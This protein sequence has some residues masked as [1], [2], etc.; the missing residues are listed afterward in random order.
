M[1]KKLTKK[2][3]GKEI[4]NKVIEY[5]ATL[6]FTEEDD[7]GG[8]IEFFKPEFNDPE[9][10]ITFYKGTLGCNSDPYAICGPGYI[11]YDFE[12]QFKEVE[13]K[14][15]AFINDLINKLKIEHEYHNA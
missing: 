7:Q 14:L 5:L 4:T 9:A 1:V 2:Q 15:D 3:V 13:T 8:Y 10:T 12:K 11:N 6:G